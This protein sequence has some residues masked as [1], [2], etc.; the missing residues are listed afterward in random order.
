MND[1]EKL[2][3]AIDDIDHE[4]VRL[5]EARMR[6]VSEVANYKAKNGIALY[7]PQRE[8]DIIERNTS[9]L[10]DESLRPHYVLFQ[11]SLMKISRNFQC[12]LMRHIKN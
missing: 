12:E 1:L 7:D 9:Y 4:M 10:Q 8:A 5:F 11:K 2:R 3:K 6:A